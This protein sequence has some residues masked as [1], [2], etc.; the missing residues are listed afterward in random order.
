MN[1][2]T[3]KFQE[4]VERLIGD[5]KPDACVDAE[6]YRLAKEF[7]ALPLGIDLWSYQFLRPDGELISTGWEQEE[8]SRGYSTSGLI[9]AVAGVAKR[10]PQFAAFK[11][12]RPPEAIVCPACQG[13]R[14]WGRD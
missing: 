14:L 1:I 7:H 10:Y 5:L 3:P 4:L 6:E 11:P 12:D 8:I 13:T 2:V 9:R